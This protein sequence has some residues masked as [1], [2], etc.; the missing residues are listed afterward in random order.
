MQ[1]TYL[2]TWKR[3]KRKYLRGGIT[4]PYY[5]YECDICYKK[6]TEKRAVDDRKRH[7]DCV[8]DGCKGTMKL[9]IS[10]CAEKQWKVR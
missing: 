5:E 10:L 2:L 1:N 6:I 3:L 8:E 9:A 7:I 4:M